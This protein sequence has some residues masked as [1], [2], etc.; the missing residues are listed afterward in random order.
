MKLLVTGGAG[1]IGSNFVHLVMETTDYEVI[2]LD[3]LTY[4][5]NLLNLTSIAKNPRFHFIK[6]DIASSAALK[7]IFDSTKIDAVVNFA[8]ETHVDRSIKNAASFVKTN[9]VGTQAL[10]DVS[11]KAKVERFVHISTDEVYGSIGE[12][13]TP[14]SED[15]PL[16][17]NNPYSASKAA[18]DYLCL[19]AFR[20][21][22]MPLIVTR[23]TNNYG[24]YQFPEKFIPLAIMNLLADKAVPIYGTG[25]NVR[26]W[27]YVADHCRALLDVLCKGKE[28]EIYNIAGNCEKHNIDVAKEIA[29]ILG[30]DEAL[31][32]FVED[33]PGHDFRYSISSRKIESE[34]NFKPL[35]S[36]QDGLRRTIEWYK[37]NGDWLKSTQTKAFRNYYK[38][39]YEGLK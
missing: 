10:L 13:E 36:F 26:D 22:R 32:R 29:H 24:P 14:C 17:P 35:N 1:F 11:R 7:R 8:A 19:A 2:I 27:I 6:G 12:N 31:I 15:S 18:A 4:A 25:M 16:H 34:L 33:R 39:M 23:C 38:H 37:N 9:I 30:K 21:H 20:T 5:G 28:G 3:K